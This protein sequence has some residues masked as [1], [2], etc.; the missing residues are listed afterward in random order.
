MTMFE[1][2]KERVHPVLGEADLRIIRLIQR[3]QKR[4]KPPALLQITGGGL[5]PSWP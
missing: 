4:E 2:E 1:R 3:Q 5:V